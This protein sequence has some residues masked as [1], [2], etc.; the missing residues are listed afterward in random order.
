MNCKC[1]YFNLE[2]E[3]NH[4]NFRTILNIPFNFSQIEEILK[5][6]A[7]PLPGE[8]FLASLTAGNRTEW[9][10]T[11]ESLFAKGSFEYIESIKTNI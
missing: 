10:K 11:R 4:E 1:E 5:S 9:A 2:D 7:K 3:E 8:E 6:N